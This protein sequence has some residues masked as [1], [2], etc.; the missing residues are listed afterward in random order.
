M[1][2]IVAQPR[3]LRLRHAWLVPG[4]ALA[5]LANAVA[6]K[7]G[8]W[9]VPLLV[10]GIV[11]HLP[12]LAGIG[13]ARPRGQLVPRAV[14]LFNALHHPLLPLAVLGLAAAG[15]LSQFWVVG[16]LTWLG[17]IAIDLG[18]GDGMRAPDGWRRG[19]GRPR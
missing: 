13:Q 19:S 16:S 6:T 2:A 7:E 10:F 17:H 4:L 1:T 5:V 14:P 12:V 11:P 15:V 8:L 9:L 3:R 18:L